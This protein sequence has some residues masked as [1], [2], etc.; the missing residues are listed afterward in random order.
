MNV[1]LVKA[2]IIDMKWMQIHLSGSE[3]GNA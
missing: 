1:L 3:P 2:H